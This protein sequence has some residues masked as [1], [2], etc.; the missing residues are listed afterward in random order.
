MKMKTDATAGL[1]SGRATALALEALAWLAGDDDRLGALMAGAGLDAAAL[2]ARAA[3][4]E[5]LGFVMDWLMQDDD[6]AAAFA[7]ARGLSPEALRAARA[8][9]PG[10]DAPDWT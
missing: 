4:P 5:F 9:L 6:A 10:G 1:A 3:D 2:R 7:Q 8:A